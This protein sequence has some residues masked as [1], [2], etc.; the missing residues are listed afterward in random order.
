MW[1]DRKLLSIKN[2]KSS[3]IKYI[4][5]SLFIT[6]LPFMLDFAAIWEVVTPEIDEKIRST[7]LLLTAFFN[8]KAYQHR[9]QVK[10]EL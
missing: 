6:I 7:L 2:L 3:T 4:A 8:L 9:V 10:T 5:A 1:I